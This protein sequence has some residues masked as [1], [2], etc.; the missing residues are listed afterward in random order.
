MASSDKEIRDKILKRFVSIFETG[1][2]STEDRID[3]IKD[4]RGRKRDKVWHQLA[5]AYSK[6]KE[7]IGISRRQACREFH[8]ILISKHNHHVTYGTVL[9]VVNSYHGRPFRSVASRNFAAAVL[10]NELEGAIEWFKHLT[11]TQRKRWGFE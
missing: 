2:P 1:P 10:N 3:E 11:S 6:D 9:E 8:E 5:I 4:P 7:S